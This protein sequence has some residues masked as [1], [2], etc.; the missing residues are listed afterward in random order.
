ME[1]KVLVLCAM[2][3]FAAAGP[4]RQIPD[5]SDSCAITCSASNKFTYSPG[6]T[7]TYDYTVQTE[8]SVDG[9]SEE[10]ATL[11][12]S[13]QANIE[14]IDDCEMVL[15]LRNMEIRESS[16]ADMSG[17]LVVSPSSQKLKQM[18]E[19]SPLRFS[20]QDGVV[21]GLCP[22]RREDPWT[23]NIKRGIL[24]AL[25]N[26]MDFHLKQ[27]ET[28][29]ESDVTGH[30]PTEY[31]RK[32]SSYWGQK[33]STRRRKDLKACTNREGFLGSL[34]TTHFTTDP[35]GLQSLPLMTSEHECDQ[36]VSEGI[37][38]SSVCREQHLFRPFS[39]H[40]GGALTTVVQTLT[41][42]SQ[43]RGISSRKD[44][45]QSRA[46]MTFD[47]GYSMK[48]SSEARARAESLLVALCEM[49]Q[50]GVTAQV[51]RTF[52]QL[53]GAVKKL[54]SSDIREVYRQLTRQR[55]CSSNNERV[56]K[57][58]LDALPMAG[59]SAAVDLMKDLMT[60][61]EVSGLQTD[62]YLASLAFIPEPT[63]QM[64]ESVQALLEN[65]KLKLE[66]MLAVSAMV[67]RY[68]QKMG[69]SSGVV[70]RVLDL[71]AS[72]INYRCS[73]NDGNIKTVLTSLRALGNAGQSRSASILNGCLGDR[74][75]LEVRVAAA[76]AYRRLPCD[77]NRRPLA[78][79]AKDREE[80]SELRTVSY[81]QM[82]T[83]P[84]QDLLSEIQVLMEDEPEDSQ[85]GSFI[86]SHLFNLKE[87]SSPLK[88]DIKKMLED[89]DLSKTFH[90]NPFKF[91]RNYEKSAYL[92]LINSG[93]QAESNVIFSAQSPVPRSV[94]TNLTVDVL[95]H[96]I[97]LLEIGGRLEGMEYLIESIQAHF[98]GDGKDKSLK[99]K[100]DEL[101]GSGYARIFGNEL[102]YKRFQGLRS[103]TSGNTFNLLDFLIKL[104]KDHDYSF[105]QSLQFLDSTV[106]TPTVAG[107]PLTL[108]VNGSA[109]VDVKAT[110]KVDLRKVSK[111]P[112][113][114][115]IEGELRPSGAVNVDGVMSVDGLL[116]GTGLKVTTSLLSSLALKGRV[117][118][119]RGRTLNVQMDMPD[120]K[121]EILDLSTKF[122]IV[123]NKAESEQKMIT[124]NRREYELCSGSVLSSMTGLEMCGKLQ[125]PNASMQSEGPYYPLTGPSSLSLVLH[126]RDS[127]SGYKLLAKR[128]ENKR[129]SIAQLSFDTP[130]SSVVR[131]VSFDM[132][133]DYPQ[134]EAEISFASPWKKTSVKGSLVSE[135]GLKSV[136]GSVIID[137]DLTYSMTADMK[138]DEDGKSGVTTFTPLM[139]LR[140]PGADDVK[141]M[142]D[143][144]I[145][146]RF[147]SLST[148]LILSGVT[149]KPLQLQTSYTN[150][151][152]DKGVSGSFKHGRSVY[153]A[154]AGVNYNI[155][156][157]KS[158]QFR[159]V[160]QVSTPNGEILRLNGQT[161]WRM[162]KAMKSEHTLTIPGLL[163]VP[164]NL[165]CDIKKK[166]R[167]KGPRYD[168]DVRLKSKPFTGKVSG[169]MV[170]SN[171]PFT[172]LKVDYNANRLGRDR[173]TMT[174]KLSNRSTGAFKKYTIS[175]T[176]EFKRNPDW[177]VDTTLDLE[178]KKKRS[179]GSLTMVLG[180]N[181]KDDSKKIILGA[182]MA[183]AVKSL[184]DADVNY[185]MK[186]IV[187]ML[188][189]DYSL[190][191]AHSHSP[192]SL[193]SEM[194]FN[195]QKDNAV[196]AKVNLKG[197]LQKQMK[198]NGD[199]SL[200]FPGHKYEV[201]S[202]L[203]KKGKQLV[204]S[205]N[206]KT[207]EGP[208]LTLTSTYKPS[209]DDTHELTSNLNLQGYT[210]I[211]MSGMVG[212]DLNNLQLQ[213][214]AVSGPHSYSLNALS[215][216]SKGPRGKWTLDLSYPAR[217]VGFSLSGG[218]RKNSADLDLDVAWDKERDK[219]AKMS[220]SMNGNHKSTREFTSTSGKVD[221]T[222]P[223]TS[224]LSAALSLADDRKRYG[225][226]TKVTLGSKANSYFSTINV[227]KPVTPQN[228]MATWSAGT[229]IRG[230]KKL[231]AV[232]NHAVDPEITNTVLTASR[233]KDNVDL[234]ITSTNKSSDSITDLTAG[235]FLTSTIRGL[236]DLNLA[237]SHKVDGRKYT[238]GAILL[239]NK[240]KYSAEL[241]MSH[242]RNG[243]QVRN[244]GELKVVSPDHDVTTT[245]QHR[246]SD[247]DVTTTI[248]SNWGRGQKLQVTMTANKNLA[249]E[250]KS[251]TSVV[252]IKTPWRPVRDFSLTISHKM[253][254]SHCE[255]EATIVRNGEQRASS[256]LD[257]I[258]GRQQLKGSFFLTNPYMDDKSGSMEVKYMSYPVTVHAGLSSGSD[259][260]I[261]TDA[262]FSK[263]S[264]SDMEAN[265]RVTTPFRAVRTVTLSGSTNRH[266]DD[267]IAKANLD[268]GIRQNYDAMITFRPEK[269]T[270]GRVVIHTP[271]TRLSSLDTGYTVSGDRS[272]LTA[273]A[274]FSLQP[275][276]D[277]YSASLNWKLGQELSGKLRI[278]TPIRDLR[279]M[280]MVANSKM[281]GQGRRSRVEV[282]YHPRQ[283]YALTSF[284]TTN[285]PIIFSLNAETPI[286]GYDS[287]GLSLKHQ[288][289]D[290]SIST[291]GE[292][293][294]LPNKVIESTLALNWKRNV[295]GSLTVK[296][297][298]QNFEESKLSLRHDGELRNFK[299][300]A[301]MEIMHET[302]TADA[303][304]KYGYATTGSISLESSM[305]DMEK[306][307][308]SF[309]KRG[310][311]ENFRSDASVAYGDQK[312]EGTLTHKLNRQVLKTAVMFNTPFSR[313]LKSSIDLS[314][315][316]GDMQGTISGQYGPKKVEGTGNLALDGR[317]F[318]ATSS[319]SYNLDGSS[320]RQMQAS[321]SKKG[322]MNDLGVAASLSCPYFADVTLNVQHTSNLPYSM[323]NSLSGSVGDYYVFK[324]EN[325][326]DNRAP[327]FS[328]SS[329]N[330][331]KLDGPLKEA[332]ISVSKKG[333]LK[334]MT[335]SSEAKLGDKEVTAEGDLRVGGG[336]NGTLHITT[337]FTSYEHLGMALSHMRNDRGFTETGSVTYMTGQTIDYSVDF[338]HSG[339][340]H[341]KLDASLE[342]PIPKLEKNT[343]T[344]RHD[345]KRNGKQCMGMAEIE[346]SLGQLA[347]TY[348]REVDGEQMTL[349][350]TLERDGEKCEG[351]MEWVP[352]SHGYK[353][354]MVFRTTRE[355]LRTSAEVQKTEDRITCKTMVS[356]PKTTL[357]FEAEGSVSDYNVDLNGKFIASSPRRNIT[358][359]VLAKRT[360]TPDDFHVES[361][362][363][364]DQNKVTAAGDFKRT[365]EGLIGKLAVTLPHDENFGVSVKHSGDLDHFSSEGAIQYLNEEVS[366]KVTFYRY[367]WR[368]LDATAELNTPSSSTKG[369]YHHVGSADSFTCSSSLDFGNS[370]KLSAD[371]RVTLSPKYD[372][373]LTLKSPRDKV[374]AEAKM[375]TV[376][377]SHSASAS[378]DLGKG[379]HYM[380]ERTLDLN[381][382]S[383]VMSGK[384]LTPLV[385]LPS[386]E[387]SSTY[388]GQ[389]DD[390]THNLVFNCPQTGVI[391]YDSRL[392]YTSIFDATCEVSL[393]SE[394]EGMED[395][396][397][398]VKNTD[399]GN[400]QNGHLM[401]RWAPSQ[402]ASLDGTYILKDYGNNKDMQADI[403][404]HTPFQQVR[405]ANLHVQHDQKDKIYIPKVELT[406]N[407][408]NLLDVEVEWKSGDS[409]S[410]A[411]ITR[412]PR[413]IQ[414]IAAMTRDGHDVR[415][416]ILVNWDR[417]HNDHN[418]RL[419]AKAKDIRD[420]YQTNLDYSLKVIHP[421]RTV[422]T[423]VKVLSRDQK[424]TSE[425]YVS[426][427]DR[428]DRKVF[429]T[430]DY[431][432]NS[433]YYGKAYDGSLKLGV[434]GR[435]LETAGS[436]SKDQQSSTVDASFSWDADRDVNKQVGLNAKVTKGDKTKA[437]LTLRL[438]AIGK[439][440]HIDHE[441]ALN[442]GST[443]YDGKTAL[444]Y[445]PDS[446]RT[447]TLTSSLKDIS[448]SYSSGNNYSLAVS[449]SHPHTNTD[450]SF[451]SHLAATG[452]R[453]SA[454]MDTVYL[455]SRRRRLN[456]ALRGEIDRLRQQIDLQLDS[457]LKTMILHGE[458]QSTEPYVIQLTNSYD[459]DDVI[460][461][462]L[463]ID[464][465]K[466]YVQFS[467]NYD[468]DK[469]DDKVV[470]K[471]GYV[472]ASA[473]SAQLDTLYD[474]QTRSEANA[475]L[476]LETPTLLHSGIYWRPQ[477][478]MELED[479]FQRKTTTYSDELRNSLNAMLDSTGQEVSDKYAA[480][481][482]ELASELNPLLNLVEGELVGVGSQMDGARK[483]LSR[484]YRRND[485]RLQDMGEYVQ[486]VIELMKRYSA[487]YTTSYNS[488]LREMRQG[489]QSMSDYNVRQQ[490]QALIDDLALRL[491]LSLA[492]TVEGLEMLTEELDTLMTSLSKRSQDHWQK[493]KNHP[494]VQ[495]V[496]GRVQRLGQDYKWLMG[497]M[498]NK[499]TRMS[500]PER[501]TSAI[502]N[503]RDQMAN[504]MYGAM[505]NRHVQKVKKV[506]NE[507]YQQGVWA[508]QYWNVEENSR[509]HLHK[510]VELLG[511]YVKQE[512]EQMT[513]QVQ[514]FRMSNVTVYDPQRGRIEVDVVI[515]VALK[516][517]EE[518]PDVT[519]YIQKAAELVD[520]YTP[521]SD[522]V[523]Q[524]YRKY[525]PWLSNNTTP[526]DDVMSQF[527]AY[528][529]S[530]NNKRGRYNQRLRQVRAN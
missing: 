205:L 122:F 89:L 225:M 126:K 148:D 42:R 8:T 19:E 488:V 223:I 239:R 136:T 260:S 266:G 130:G 396:R 234:R 46:E 95:G 133:I 349:E 264:D 504:H 253:S 81:L 498:G 445:S 458:V 404:L 275:L 159:P 390:F 346:T 359:L 181:R 408:E 372:I 387:L 2:F 288:H 103:L 125:F 391:K 186:A 104:S 208:L 35:S 347:V 345:L 14:V 150:T 151:R 227:L 6:Q 261:T 426:M 97:N 350:G 47:H 247:N 219:D 489:L 292:L 475:I 238:S 376:A 414:V 68:C 296:T 18:L 158:A 314:K 341:L 502:Y 195:Y 330:S 298:F 510:L 27:A 407:E 518:M 9:A 406:L 479:Y 521:D 496:H 74:V 228:L 513:R 180:K 503:A 3:A 317:D 142:G 420:D 316:Q 93:A 236:D 516:S 279:Y 462:Q 308:G 157:G 166:G 259:Q 215:K 243:W 286:E 491:K 395:L 297:P 257:Y 293:Q 86:H 255:H 163:A 465:S 442:Q 470:V 343:L 135:A 363:S 267:V 67:H 43:R 190:N 115:H 59:S 182:S 364:L 332:S 63:A 307:E 318:T 252:D 62:I 500:L 299:S 415:G 209:K 262:S 466:R 476:L 111:S 323:K 449:I 301:E 276:V 351:H 129:S 140:S 110:G 107:L 55:I 405:T 339:F 443:V 250:E 430:L 271:L 127:H 403:T 522:A 371:L 509:E 422:S 450:I 440:V 413:P 278:N 337:P 370:Q 283:M 325:S 211:K 162:G 164:I 306:I 77:V 15:L 170:L 229:P 411:V 131:A 331:Y 383:M 123:H 201:G 31:E 143:V 326:L 334:D 165:K 26:S 176:V 248:N 495:R 519:A 511:D 203:K 105:T 368:R 38:E 520:H 177:N 487:S 399:L 114:L 269:L 141:L 64:I 132:M 70:D 169:V 432:H 22:S 188:D 393:S 272:D 360:G 379:Q 88:Q 369:E 30:C 240:D 459:R 530:R 361:S 274:D 7:Y 108:S 437:D 444:S 433:H 482:E 380:V 455:T 425:G 446:R 109:T 327:S 311:S 397:L 153:S 102:L 44:Q 128:V 214:Q 329:V 353:H 494:D 197:N 178:H 290:G 65:D 300:H 32:E 472:N 506:A 285:M 168:L 423:G 29:Q 199:A 79:L 13:G 25:Q 251:V 270:L 183:R 474:G 53:V 202:G 328:A 212:L 410:F 230:W 421:S 48:D 320:P 315:K 483:T 175:S 51:P 265:V 256:R 11:A 5:D 57:F 69:C 480:I 222:S 441:M 352:L 37:I 324:S 424:T 41:Y 12:I 291:H 161:D 385:H 80:S 16:P 244:N 146:N 200:S 85:V 258:L 435:T 218:L 45:V 515:P 100:L 144:K 152:A 221:F 213:T 72:D 198:V 112:R 528:K 431:S 24:S 400:T 189:V 501:Y 92:K 281:S 527:E 295:D 73:V 386:V 138:V 34:H 481:T 78:E 147:A 280:Q 377:N 484:M 427:D 499:V 321:V 196:K 116:T 149:R 438:P 373:T 313:M 172:N 505:Q 319:I 101:K 52:F 1:A 344:L 90:S 358:Y 384:L 338:S 277:K 497:Y 463:K 478:V 356:L 121:M 194:T 493:I 335:F 10:R 523:V 75:P 469:P 33:L 412:S 485:L 434:P 447:L 156:R 381:P 354:T 235:V 461:S 394:I 210:P 289:D 436:F 268:Y 94:S 362:I 155:R 282:E 76:Q 120:D 254:D 232:V 375:E 39:A 439:E 517:L 273:T 119:D 40:K 429:Y 23:L 179:G 402:Q 310:S 378:L 467:T 154:E 457:P 217:T 137:D 398:E 529:P 389:I 365:A 84:S 246:S 191:G 428:A 514:F 82:M 61:E 60:S 367:Q 401:V 113:T 322:D 71:L 192:N 336:I 124:D 98:F 193:S 220:M 468:L 187:P 245:W 17:S 451:N 216:I 374:V 357:S 139:L 241:D 342:T 302:V 303:Q 4:M 416:D 96:S 167:R 507:A 453:L 304:F 348:K 249:G 50:N 231:G 206:M 460:Q 174:G 224:H 36:V 340:K 333:D 207:H 464:V 226:D 312:I 448:D 118:L 263:T 204:H 524:M 477:A 452:D 454:A 305:N 287:L 294:Y 309:N 117:E 419:Q 58:F 512:L 160:V 20:F 49:T 388:K 490:Y 171:S 392:K 471:A 99:N 242:S 66:A 473:I 382:D 87:T 366:G 486:D 28:V 173:I 508:Y 134:R 56:K 237:L 418:V 355:V 492:R 409:P 21:E 54:D 525:T 456:M 145:E 526:E 83:C 185:K 417:D 106:T 284:Y 233:G 184:A 91:S